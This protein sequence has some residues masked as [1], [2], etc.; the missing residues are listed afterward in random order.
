MPKSLP[1]N[2]RNMEVTTSSGKSVYSTQM[3]K[4]E[5]KETSAEKAKNVTK[6]DMSSGGVAKGAGG[7]GGENS[8]S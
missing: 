6:Q 3:L 7:L 4:G 8:N 2:L 5:A 1:S